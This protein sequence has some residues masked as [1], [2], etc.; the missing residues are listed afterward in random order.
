VGYRAGQ[1]WSVLLGLRRDHLSVG[2]TDPRDTAGNPLN[3]F[4]FFSDEFGSETEMGSQVSDLR[5]K[6]WI[7]YLGLQMTR[8]GF[9]ASLLYSPFA[10]VQVRVPAPLRIIQLFTSEGESPSTG[11][12]YQFYQFQYSVMQ[13]AAF[14]EANVEYDVAVASNVAIKL[15]GSAGW[16]NMKGKGSFSAG[17]SEEAFSN[18]VP[19]ETSGD[20]VTDAGNATC[21]RG[22]LSGGLSAS[23]TF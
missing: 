15:W 22:T 12:D 7:P 11:A 1:D 18:G 6:L 16:F 14:V 8:P 3:F 10:T 20:H 21:S 4:F 23:W 2:L 9:R 13:P 17:I 19:F 5:V